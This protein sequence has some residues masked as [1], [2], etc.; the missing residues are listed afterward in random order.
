MALLSS[1]VAIRIAAH[2]GKGREM[3]LDI[4][5]SAFAPWVQHYVT[6]SNALS[7]IQRAATPAE[8][9]AHRGL[10]ARRTLGASNLV[11]LRSHLSDAWGER[12]PE[13]APDAAVVSG[14]ACL[15]TADL[16]PKALADAFC[17]L[18]PF[19]F[20][21]H[22]C[23]RALGMGRLLQQGYAPRAAWSPRDWET[24]FPFGGVRAQKR[25]SWIGPA[26]PSLN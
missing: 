3:G 8:L 11:L 10:F 19:R 4:A 7:G 26:N 2:Y 21:N 23:A 18:A 17:E 5:A 22:R 9:A 6:A 12:L 24:R 16:S 20:A 1:V 13:D 25:T 15:L 14:I